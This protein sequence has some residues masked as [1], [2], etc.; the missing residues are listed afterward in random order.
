MLNWLDSR[1]GS[2]FQSIA[3]EWQ[4]AGVTVAVAPAQTLQAWC[5]HVQRV[6]D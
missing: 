5:Q 4:P 1:N 6:A 2:S 3:L